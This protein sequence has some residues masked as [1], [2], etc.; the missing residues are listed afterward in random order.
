M[1]EAARRWCERRTFDANSFDIAELIAAKESTRV[2][3]VVP[4]RDEA[5]TIGAIVE[6]IRDAH[7]IDSR[8]VDELLVIDSD[9]TDT[10]ADVSLKAGATVYSAAQIRPDL[11]WRPGKGEAMWKS[12][13]VAT[14]DIVVFI[15]GDLTT[16]TPDYV[17]GLLG[18]L[19]MNDD[20]ISLVKGFYDR[21]LDGAEYGIAQ[22]GRVTELTARPVINLWWPD[23]AGV[24]QPLAGEWAARRSLLEALPFP[25]G[26]GIEIAALIDTYEL[27]GLNSI[28]Q[29]DL[30]VRGHIHQDLASLSVVAAEV[31]A[32]ATSRKFG[33]S[34]SSDAEI[35]HLARVE[36][37][38]TREW[39]A[40]AVNAMERPPRREVS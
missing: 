24:I 4:A 28:A 15:D 32:A 19:L 31:I 38:D 30:G 37:A 2:S 17:T 9:S 14:G 3:V 8:L 5:E 34:T 36:D 16:F 22:G 39:L 21:A 20:D 29:V 6:S 25:S 10:T 13:F 7:V 1:N 18:P 33:R 12:L 26:Y 40:R 27:R 35:A 23:L 11:G